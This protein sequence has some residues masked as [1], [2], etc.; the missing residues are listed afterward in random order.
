M[1][2]RGIAGL[3]TIALLVMLI[4]PGCVSMDQINALEQEVSSLQNELS[5]VSNRNQE[6]ESEIQVYVT[7]QEF[8]T[9]L[10]NFITK[11]EMDNFQ[12]LRDGLLN[13]LST[14]LQKARGELE[15]LAGNM[16]KDSDLQVL[17]N[18]VSSLEEDFSQVNFV[19]SEL[20]IYG[21]YSSASEMIEF[22][23]GLVD[24]Y[25]TLNSVE[26]KLQRLKEAMTLFVQD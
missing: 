4:L 2:K 14:E 1:K 17:S 20:M 12:E 9:E 11:V 22:V 16:A 8:T 13:G 3:I 25:D 21:E 10:K 19:I 7:K 26:I 5:A 15:V 23:C 6:M 18:R 24:L